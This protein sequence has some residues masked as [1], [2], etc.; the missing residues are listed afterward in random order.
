MIRLFTPFIVLIFSFS[1]ALA[2][3]EP[4]PMKKESCVLVEGPFNGFLYTPPQQH[5]VPPP[6]RV[7]DLITVNFLS[8]GMVFGNTCQAWP[9]EAMSAM[10]YAAGLWEGYLNPTQPISINACWSGDLGG[11]TLGAAGATN[12]YLLNGSSDTWYPIALLEEIVGSNINGNNSEI[13]AVFNAN[14]NNWYFGTDGNVTLG[15][16]DFVTVCMH[17][18]GHGLGFSGGSELDDG[19]GLPECDGIEGQGCYGF[20]VFDTYTPDIYS[21]QME[22]SNGTPLT[23][24][25][26]PSI[27]VGDLFLGEMGGLFAGS[28]T[29]EASNGSPAK[30]YTPSSYSRGSSYSHWDLSSFPSELMKP[31]LSVGQ[32]IHDP[33]LALDLFIDM[34]WAAAVLPVDLVA[35]DVRKSGSSVTLNWETSMEENNAGFEIQRSKDGKDWKAIDFVEGMGYAFLY[36]YL[37]QNPGLGINYYRLIQTDFDGRTEASPVRAIYIDPTGSEI[38]VWPIPAQSEIFVAQSAMETDEQGHIYNSQ[39]QIVQ[40]VLVSATTQS[41]DI[42]NMPGGNYWLKLGNSDPVPFFK[43]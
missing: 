25:E 32:A 8:S 42:T 12:F 30:L 28:S 14:R 20:N 7:Q 4:Y 43:N 35:F 41:I 2:Q 1:L 36:S 23:S 29:V 34:G 21:R 22:R 17:E 6:G 39:G 33:G 5:A 15:Q 24:I 10:E 40:S 13:Q 3:N 19:V 37:D 11:S 9:A 26:N 31:Q 38:T 27:S 18:L 16:I